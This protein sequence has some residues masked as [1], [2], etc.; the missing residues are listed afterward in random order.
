MH[1]NLTKIILLP[2]DKYLFNKLSLIFK[3]RIVRFLHKY[4]NKCN[5][6]INRKRFNH[7]KLNF[8]YQSTLNNKTK[9]LSIFFKEL[10]LLLLS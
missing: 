6:F 8:S 9:N 5:N 3:L 4:Y 10:N 2:I 1:L 7:F